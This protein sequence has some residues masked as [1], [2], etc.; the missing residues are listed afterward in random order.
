MLVIII[1]EQMLL[2]LEQVLVK[3]D[4]VNMLLQ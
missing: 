3:L 2:L 4:K 1:K